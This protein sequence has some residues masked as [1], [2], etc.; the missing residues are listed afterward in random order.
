MQTKSSFKT[1]DLAYIGIFVALI[2][3]CSWIT[4]PA[5]VPFTLQTFGVFL[6]IAL[7]GFKRGTIAVAVYILLGAV[8]VPVFS[9]FTGGIGS[10][11]G[12]TGGYIVGFLF[13]ALISGAIIEKFGKKLPIM[14]PAMLLGLLACYILGTAWFMIVYTKSKGDVGLFTTLT[15]CVFPFIIPDCIKIVL[16]IFLSKRLS[17]RIPF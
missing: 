8:G 6:T 10:L 2:A 11:L 7:L 12:N 17:R 14:V 13:S 15:W 9:N 1:I 4:I 3:I 5:T 16:A